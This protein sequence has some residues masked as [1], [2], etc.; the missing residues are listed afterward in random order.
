MVEGARLANVKVV[1]IAEQEPMGVVEQ[2]APLNASIKV[3]AVVRLLPPAAISAKSIFTAVQPDGVVNEYQTSYL[4]PAQD[5]AIPELV[6]LNKV[7]DV[8]TQAVPGVREVGVEQS[9]DC[10]NEILE[11]KIKAHNAVMVRVV[12]DMV[13]QGF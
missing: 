6:A 10:P 3:L 11:N 9:S 13:L 12:G 8:F 1:P 2:L 5:P 4:V 7:P